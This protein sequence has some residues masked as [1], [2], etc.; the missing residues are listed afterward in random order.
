MDKRPPK[1]ACPECGEMGAVAFEKSPDE[2][3]WF[4]FACGSAG[5]N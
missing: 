2:G 1:P 4:C 3:L 5:R